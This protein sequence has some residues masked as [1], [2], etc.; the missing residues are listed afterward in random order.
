MPSKKPKVVLVIG[1]QT[2]LSICSALEVGGD[3][4]ASTP[5]DSSGYSDRRGMCVELSQAQVRS[6]GD[7]GTGI[8]GSV[9]VLNGVK[10]PCSSFA[11]TTS[12]SVGCKIGEHKLVSE[13]CNHTYQ[14]D[15]PCHQHTGERNTISCRI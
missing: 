7:L 15:M 1:K 4:G 2:S 10:S 11:A 12:K 3:R 14:D 5:C 8:L 6:L 13:K 9:V